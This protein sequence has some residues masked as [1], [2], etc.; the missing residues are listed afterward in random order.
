MEIIRPA[1]RLLKV[2]SDINGS[3]PG[4]SGPLYIYF[5][6]LLSKLRFA[7]R[8]NGILRS[9]ASAPFLAAEFSAAKSNRDLRFGWGWTEIVRRFDAGRQWRVA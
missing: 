8:G 1:L 7:L 4:G 9:K 5:V 6:S 2:E 3:L